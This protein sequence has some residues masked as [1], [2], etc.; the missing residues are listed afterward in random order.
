MRHGAKEPFFGVKVKDLK[1]IQKN[2]CLVQHRAHRGCPKSIKMNKFTNYFSL[3]F[4]VVQLFIFYCEVAQMNS[5]SITK[6]FGTPSTMLN[7]FTLAVSFQH[8]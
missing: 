7:C 4:F 6:A 5:Q 3:S 1:K 2:Q 8:W